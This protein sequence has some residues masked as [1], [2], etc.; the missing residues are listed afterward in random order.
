MH[1]NLIQRE[2]EEKVVLD[3]EVST[4]GLKFQK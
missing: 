2:T 4:A 3:F 1:I